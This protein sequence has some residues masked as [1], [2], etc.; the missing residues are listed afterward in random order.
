MPTVVPPPAPQMANPA[1]ATSGQTTLALSPIGGPTQIAVIQFGL[2][3]SGL[4]GEDRAVLRDVARIQRQNGGMLRV[5]GHAAQDISGTSVER[6][7]AGNHDVSMRRGTTIANELIR[8]GVP[9]ESIVV[10]AMA[11]ED[12]IYE[13]RTARGLAANRRAEIFL[14]L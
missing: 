13:T 7:R 12:P 3:S 14:D 8:L 5:Y 1:T 11:D 2:G 9:A 4:S 6:L 10:E